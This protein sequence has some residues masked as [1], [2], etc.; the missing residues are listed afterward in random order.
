MTGKYPLCRCI[1]RVLM[2]TT[3]WDQYLAID[4]TLASLICIA[5]DNVMYVP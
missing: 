4:E 1:L 3:A 5:P 2:Q